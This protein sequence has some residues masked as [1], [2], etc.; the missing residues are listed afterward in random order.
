[1]SNR[2]VKPGDVESVTLSGTVLVN[3]VDVIGT[4]KL[5]I[6]LVAGVSGDV[7]TYGIKG[8]YKLPKVT[9]A[10]ITRGQLVYWDVSAGNV[11]D[12]QATP[13]AGDFFCGYAMES[14]GAGVLEIAVDINQV[15]PAV[16]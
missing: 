9:G 2:F 6:A 11:D 12:D 7:I 13:A 14:A 16:T 1:M 5:G 15:A 4:G 10:V 3:D 8:V